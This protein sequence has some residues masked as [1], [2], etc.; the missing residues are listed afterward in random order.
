MYI[1]KNYIPYLDG[2]RALAVI[3][4]IL[5]HSDNTWLPGGYLGVEVFFVISGFIITN[6]LYNEW[7][8]TG[9]INF[10]RFYQ[11]R[12]KRLL[13]ALVTLALVVWIWV[14]LFHPEDINQILKD[15]PYGLSF[16]AN[17]DYILNNRS[18]FEA[19]GRQRL[20]EHLW[21]LGIEFQFYI[22]WPFVCIW[23]FQKK[24]Y[25]IVMIMVLIGLFGYAWMS[26]LYIPE[27]DPSRIYFGTDT[28]IGGFLVGAVTA[29]LVQNW[30]LQLKVIY[31][32]AFSLLGILMIGILLFFLNTLKS[33]NDFLYYGGFALSGIVSGVIIFY[34]HSI[35]L[36]RQDSY[37]ARL[38]RHDPLVTLLSNRI[39]VWLGL[40]SYGIYLWHWP[41]FGLVQKDIDIDLEDPFLFILRLILILSF[42]EISYRLIETPIRQGFIRTLL[43]KQ[44]KN[45]WQMGMRVAILVFMFIGGCCLYLF[46]IEAMDRKQDNEMVVATTS[47]PQI[48]KPPSSSQ[49][50]NTPNIKPHILYDIN[51]SNKYINKVQTNKDNQGRILAIGDSV[52]IS[53]FAELL[54]HLPGSVI[55][56]RV[57]RQMSDASILLKDTYKPKPGS[58]VLVHLGHNGQFGKWHLKHIMD[59][60]PE[61][62]VLV[63]IN[64]K[65]PRNYENTN[66]QLLSD[67]AN[68]HSEVQLIDWKGKSSQDRKNFANDGM[69]LTMHGA[70]S[71]AKTVRNA[72]C[73]LDMQ[74]IFCKQPL[75]AP[76]EVQYPKATEEIIASNSP[77]TKL[78][79]KTRK[80]KKS[81][82]NRSKIGRKNRKRNR[83]RRRNRRKNR[84]KR[85]R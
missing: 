65:L 78:Q 69:H 10:W 29:M 66:N 15:L 31:D 44:R 21:S 74:F 79:P 26:Y 37:E 75:P 17:L 62:V 76:L 42:T 81:S 16:T 46:T 64:L 58:I 38:T 68:H 50:S 30:P 25:V 19:L 56:A 61:H 47:F 82:R 71:Y 39:M 23:L 70:R 67:F 36:T 53:G 48:Q 85:E 20:F 51:P 9:N 28:R 54:Q 13:P 35:W 83:N 40:R 6:L 27:Q 3:A 34:C 63:F 1:P 33:N 4:V 24:P 14:L 12:L 32:S 11:K 5:Y 49:P 80:S 57:G 77:T 18:Y 52:M 2:L 45:Y 73:N 72:L 41:I 84:K 43:T 22:I 60:I 8:T 7:Q 55:D 59:R